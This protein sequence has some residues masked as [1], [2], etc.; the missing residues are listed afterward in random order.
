MN[1]SRSLLVLGATGQVGTLVAQHLKRSAVH[2]S[3][4]TRRKASLD[5]LADQ[6]GASRF[7]DLDDPRTF[8]EA[9]KDITGLFLIN[10]Y[11]VNMLVQ[12]KTLT[13]AA[14]RNGVNH[15]VHLGAFTRDHDAYATVF[16]WHQMIEA[17]VRD[18]G[19][20][21]TNLHPNMFMQNL[22][23]AWAVKDGLYSVYTSKPVGF[24]A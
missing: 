2:F 22:L 5:E 14:K 12:S 16:A 23:A 21:W 6:F 20:A 15:I 4:G 7:I 24:T 11:T 1:S 8:D 18:S 10:G 3:A 9:L 19:I 17:Y 13:D